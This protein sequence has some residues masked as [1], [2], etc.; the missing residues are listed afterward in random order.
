MKITTKIIKNELDNWEKETELNNLNLYA[1]YVRIL[2]N[3]N[4][5]WGK[6]A[7]ASDIFECL[8]GKEYNLDMIELKSDIFGMMESFINEY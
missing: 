8:D 7:L 2:N 4:E 1:E 3:T 5:N 6:N